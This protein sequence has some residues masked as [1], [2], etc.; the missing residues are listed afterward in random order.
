MKKI[1]II[2]AAI[3]F[4]IGMSAQSVTRNGNV[5]KSERKA[6]VKDTLVSQYKYEDSKGNT[7][8]IIVNKKTGACWVCKVSKNG[9]F[10]R[11]YMNKDIKSQIC[12][13]LNIAL[14]ED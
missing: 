8:P 10:Y 12:K 5:F 9:K 7:Y 14:K 13:E 4:S 2:M 11:Q 1:I 6:Y 3:M